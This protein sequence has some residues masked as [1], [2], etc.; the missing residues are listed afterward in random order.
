MNT[1]FSCLLYSR[2]LRVSGSNRWLLIDSTTMRNFLRCSL[3]S[4]PRHLSRLHIS[5]TKLKLNARVQLASRGS[6]AKKMWTNHHSLPDFWNEI[7]IHMTVWGLWVPKN[8]EHVIT[9]SPHLALCKLPGYNHMWRHMEWL[10]CSTLL[11][12]VPRLLETLPGMNDSTLSN[13]TD[14]KKLLISTLKCQMYH[15]GSKEGRCT[16]LEKLI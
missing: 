10:F 9:A 14:T 3:T 4:I 15:M 1:G 2:N 16:F 12:N 8:K 11:R 6:R 5:S 13:R 7:L